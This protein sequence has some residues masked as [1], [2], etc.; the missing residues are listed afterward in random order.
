MSFATIAQPFIKIGIPVFPLVPGGKVPPKD[1]HF[2][3]EAK[4][5]KAGAHVQRDKRMDQQ[6]LWFSRSAHRERQIVYD[7]LHTICMQAAEA[8]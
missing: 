8:A 6:I 2:L 7:R 1:F 4:A 3:Q 5:E